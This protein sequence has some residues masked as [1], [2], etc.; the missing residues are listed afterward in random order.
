[1]IFYKV[2]VVG[3][4]CWLLERHVKNFRVARWGLW[5]I[6]AVFAAVIV[7]HLLNILIW[8]G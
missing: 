6:T 1:M 8:K 4:L 2:F 7:W 3:V 5:F